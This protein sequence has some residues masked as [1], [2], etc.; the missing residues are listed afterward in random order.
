[1]R[2]L[3]IS[4]ATA[5]VMTMT[6]SAA[7]AQVALSTYADAEGFIDVQALTCAELANTWQGR[8]R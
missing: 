2:K 1:M 8:C 3:L 5:L 7:R 4:A 6:G